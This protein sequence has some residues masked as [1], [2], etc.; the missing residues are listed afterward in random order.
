MESSPNSPPSIP[1][2]LPSHPSSS[3]SLTFFV[4]LTLIPSHTLIWETSLHQPCLYKS[5]LHHHHHPSHSG[6]LRSNYL[7]TVHHD[8]YVL[9]DN[10]LKMTMFAY[11]S[12]IHLNHHHPSHSHQISWQQLSHSIKTPF[13]SKY[14]C[15]IEWENNKSK[16]MCGWNM[17]K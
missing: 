13:L 9:K 4:F 6:Y 8:D 7:V 14:K 3:L 15:G 2:L 10:T 1:F 16:Q 17:Y 12:P 5:S 11:I